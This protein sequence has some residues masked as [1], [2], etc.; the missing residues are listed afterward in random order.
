MAPKRTPRSEPPR[1]AAA[2]GEFLE[3]TNDGV[4]RYDVGLSVSTRCPA[5]EQAQLIL[6]RARVGFCKLVSRPHS[7]FVDATVAE[8]DRSRGTAYDEVVASACL[9]VFAEDGFRFDA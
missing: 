4:W 1:D 8:I 6:S 3:L 7:H 2:C 5:E 9:A